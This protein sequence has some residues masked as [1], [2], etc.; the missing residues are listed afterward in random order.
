MGKY[1]NAFLTPLTWILF[2]TSIFGVFV[3]APIW[4]IANAILYWVGLLH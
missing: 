3:V 4:I 2:F 1:A